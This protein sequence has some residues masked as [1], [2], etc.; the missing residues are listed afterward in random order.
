MKWRQLFER[1]TADYHAT[2]VRANVLHTPFDLLCPVDQVVQLGAAI[3][4]LLQL[5]HALQRLRDSRADRQDR[6]QLGDFID[7]AEWNIQYAAHITQRRFRAQRAIGDDLRHVIA[8]ILVGDVVQH[9]AAAAVGEVGV[10]IRHLQALGR[11]KALEQQFVRHR[12]NIGDE[13]AIQHQRCAGRTA[14]QAG[15]TL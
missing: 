2:G 3:V 15:N 4:D 8:A 9:L 14:R 13:Q 5:R 12:I 10:D 11:E 7:L 1:A 6:Y